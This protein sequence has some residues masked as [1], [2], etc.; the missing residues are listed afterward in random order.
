MPKRQN[1]IAPEFFPL[2]KKEEDRATS[3][4]LAVFLNVYEFRKALMATLNRN[5]KK[6]G[7]DVEAFLHPSFGGKYSET[8]IPDG[9]IIHSIL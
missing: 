2:T 4:F 7:R 1:G 8:D 5:A 3:I 6:S 9:L